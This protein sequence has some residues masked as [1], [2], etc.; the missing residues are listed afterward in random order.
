MEDGA[1]S[2]SNVK[3]L[4]AGGRIGGAFVALSSHKN[5][6]VGIILVAPIV[7]LSLLAPVIAWHDPTATSVGPTFAS[8]SI[9]YPFGT[10]NFGRDLFSRV[11]YAGRNSLIL[12]V[13]ATVIAIAA[14][15]SI[16]IISGYAGGMTDE[17]IMRIMDALMSLPSLLLAL[18]IVAMLGPN[19]TNA[20]VAIALV[21][22]P[23]VARIA[24]S[25]TLSVKQV[26]YIKAAR[27]RAE[28]NYYIYIHEILPN[29]TGPIIVEGTIRIGFAIFVGT[30]LSFLGLGTQP[31]IPDLGFM[32]AQARLHMW[33]SLWY[34]F[35]PSLFLGLMI[36]G[37]NLIGDGVRD[38]LDPEI[39][40]E[41][42]L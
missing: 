18:L 21:Y 13:T 42:Q 39:Q 32:I 12:G 3:D 9:E 29:V 19:L 30:S 26:D 24:R 37:F 5:L 41:S 1:F 22:T 15:A 10:D 16:G 35:W 33:S 28:P 34:L 25:S 2:R 8:P 4:L 23:R 17:A 14:G 38:V 27:A 40:M 20:I 36:L 31:P 11:L 7:A 6:T